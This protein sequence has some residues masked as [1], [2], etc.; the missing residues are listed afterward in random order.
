MLVKVN[1][2]TTGHRDVL[3]CFSDPH[4]E[5]TLALTVVTARELWSQLGD[6]LRIVDAE[7]PNS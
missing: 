4:D 2:Y 7:H 6:V 1:A 3:V 5:L